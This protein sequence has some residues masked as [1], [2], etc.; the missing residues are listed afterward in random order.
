[1]SNQ[2]IDFVI[3]ETMLKNNARIIKFRNEELEIEKIGV[4]KRV[5]FPKAEAQDPGF[6]KGVNTSKVTL[7]PREIIVPFEIGDVF[8]EENIEGEAVEERI[9][10]MMATTL[11]NNLEQLYLLGDSLGPAISPFDLFDVGSTTDR[12]IDSYLG[13]FDGWSR[14]A[15][16]ANVVDAQGANVGLSIFGQMIR[17]MPT[18]FRRNKQNL[19][20]YLS[21]DLWQLFEEKLATRATGLGDSAAG[22]GTL[23]PGP[24]GVQAVPIPL[25]DNQPQVVEHVQLTGTDE[26]ALRF[27][28]ISS[29]IVNTVTLGKTPETPFIEDT[30][31]SIDAVAGSITR[32]GGAIGD[33][34]FVKVTYNANPQILLTHKSNFIVGIGRDVRIEKD[35]DIFKGVNQY[36]I[37]VKVAVEFEELDALVKAKNIG[38]DI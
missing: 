10:R 18:K 27:A 25:W 6:R 3:D 38:T 13:L 11:A 30:D 37:T 32:I 15:D 23:S 5:A 16:G 2:F 29:V 24:F 22:G 20:F 12:V 1:Q 8:K 21:P 17:A 4:G 31:Y 34:D 19:R 33:G 28:P 9:I 14:I 36:A 7:K 35:R 26:I